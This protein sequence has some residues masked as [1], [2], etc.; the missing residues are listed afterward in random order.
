MYDRTVISTLQSI[1]FDLNYHLTALRGGV[2]AT[3]G[4]V[5]IVGVEDE[6]C[7]GGHEDG[8]GLALV[9]A[10]IAFAEIL[11][12]SLF[13]GDGR[14]A[15]DLLAA[16]NCLNVDIFEV[17]FRLA[18]ACGLGFVFLDHIEKLVAVKLL[19]SCGKTRKIGARQKFERL[20]DSSESAVIFYVF[21]G[22]KDHSFNPFFAEL[23]TRIHYNKICLQSQEEGR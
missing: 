15:D 8:L 7:A 13:C 3:A 14:D 16:K 19:L 11:C 22:V 10:V 18:C 20:V 17:P 5:E 6:E 1:T 21:N 12:H 23:L 4:L 2:Y 9:E